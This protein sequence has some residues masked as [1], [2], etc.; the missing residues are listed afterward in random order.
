[1]S[2]YYIDCR[3]V[4]WQD[5]SFSAEAD[6]IEQVVEQLAD[7]IGIHYNLKGFGHE[8]YGTLRQHIRRREVVSNQGPGEH[9]QVDEPSPVFERSQ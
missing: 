3:D 2:K 4:G 9:Q 7:H 5:C 1:M 6:T 8:L